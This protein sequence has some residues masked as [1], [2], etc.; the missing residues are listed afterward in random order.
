VSGQE[1]EIK[2][3]NERRDGVFPKDKSLVQIMKEHT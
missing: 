1:V 2:T 3:G